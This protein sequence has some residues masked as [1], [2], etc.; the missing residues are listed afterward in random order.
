M[1]KS[2]DPEFKVRAVRMVQQ[3]REGY[4]SL[5]AT[6]TAIGGEL[7]VSRETLRSW[8]R[9]AEID[10]GHVPGVTTEENEEMARLRKENRRLREANE[11]L[12]KA[13]VFFAGELDPR[14]H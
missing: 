2:Y 8:V 12:K 9:Q 5:T 10:A 13:T 4:R 1:K 3:H 14:N 11:I 7:G 6:C